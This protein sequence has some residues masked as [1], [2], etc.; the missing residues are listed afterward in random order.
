MLTWLAEVEREFSRTSGV[1]GC[2]TLQT[3]DARFD[4]EVFFPHP[5]GPGPVS[6]SRKDAFDLGTPGRRIGTLFGGSFYIVVIAFCVRRRPSRTKASPL[7][8]C[9]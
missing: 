7:W 1:D 3:C 8:T 6:I 5:T 2:K 4:V 9:D